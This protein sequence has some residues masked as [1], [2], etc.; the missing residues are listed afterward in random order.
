[1]GWRFV[2][3]WVNR[4]RGGSRMRGGFSKFAPAVFEN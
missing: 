4:V 3:V 2:G 1:M